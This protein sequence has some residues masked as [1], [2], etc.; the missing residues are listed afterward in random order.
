MKRSDQEKQFHVPLDVFSTVRHVAHSDCFH[1]IRPENY[2]SILGS[3]IR[4]SDA[5]FGHVR[6]S[7]ETALKIISIRRVSLYSIHSVTSLLQ[8]FEYTAIV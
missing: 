6:R 8:I 2:M 3:W 4:I 5:K 7:C 1:L